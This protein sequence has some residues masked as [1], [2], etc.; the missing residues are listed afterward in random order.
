MLSFPQLPT[1][2]EM[3]PIYTTQTTVWPKELLN[4][5]GPGAGPGQANGQP[6]QR[7][8][9]LLLHT[10]ISALLKTWAAFSRPNFPAS[11]LGLLPSPTKRRPPSTLF[12]TAACMHPQFFFGCVFPPPREN[13]DVMTAD[14]D[15]HRFHGSGWGFVS[16]FE[17]VAEGHPSH[18][19]RPCVPHPL[20]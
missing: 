7:P 5:A 9:I 12:C 17:F 19:R 15:I 8:G 16:L 2:P 14:G 1:E 20:L 18:T 10:K 4:C 3:R 13:C 6:G 11:E